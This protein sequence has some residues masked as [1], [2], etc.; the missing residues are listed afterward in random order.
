MNHLC[1]FIDARIV[2]AHGTRNSRTDTLHCFLSPQQD[3][4][5]SLD[6]VL[7]WLRRSSRDDTDKQN[8]APPEFISRLGF[9]TKGAFAAEVLR[10]AREACGGVLKAAVAR[11]KAEKALA[12][13]V[14]PSGTTPAVSPF[15]AAI[16]DSRANNNNAAAPKTDSRLNASSIGITDESQF[17]KLGGARRRLDGQGGS[18]GY[19]TVT[20]PAPT[21]KR[22]QPTST[23]SS[24]TAVPQSTQP[25]LP[26]ENITLPSTPGGDKTTPRR[27]TAVL[28]TS[29]SLGKLNAPPLRR[30][31]TL[32]FPG[33]STKKQK[34][35]NASF[36][37]ASETS[38]PA[39]AQDARSEAEFESAMKPESSYELTDAQTRL[40]T[41]HA[42]V[43]RF[44]IPP[45]LAPEVAFLGNLLSISLEVV[46]VDREGYTSKC[47]STIT[48]APA[49]RRYAAFVIEHC[50]S[51][52]FGV[53]ERL[54]AGLASSVS[55][56]RFA[57]KCHSQLVFELGVTRRSSLMEQRNGNNEDRSGGSDPSTSQESGTTFNF[58]N[59]A[60]HDPSHLDGGGIP[61]SGS[62]FGGAANTERA[63]R[64]REKSRDHL[65]TRLRQLASDGGGGGGGVSGGRHPPT[66][67]STGGRGHRDNYPDSSDSSFNASRSLLQSVSTENTRWFAELLVQRLCR[68]AVAGEHDAELSSV[69]APGR[70]SKLHKRLTGEGAKASTMQGDANS[71]GTASQPN[72]GGDRGR[73]RGRGG[74]TTSGFDRPSTGP[75]S[76]PAQ[77]TGA[78]FAVLFPSAQR[79]IVRLIETCDSHR[80]AQAL[81]RSLVNALHH[82]DPNASGHSVGD[83]DG[84]DDEAESDSDTD[85]AEHYDSGGVKVSQPGDGNTT[86]LPLTLSPGGVVPSPDDRKSGRSRRR[87][88]KLITKFPDTTVFLSGGITERALAL[89]AVA[90]VIGVL[91]FGS[92]AAGAGV[93]SAAALAPPA[94]VDCANALKR[95]IKNG[96]LLLTAPWVLSFLRFLPWDAEAATASCHLEPLSILRAVLRSPALCPDRGTPVQ[97]SGKD[98]D[99]DTFASQKSKV[100]FGAPQLALRSVLSNGLSIKAP[101]TPAARVTFCQQETL[102]SG[103]VLTNTAWPP[104]AALAQLP[105]TRRDPRWYAYGQ[106]VGEDSDTTDSSYVDPLRHW[107]VN[108]GHVHKSLGMLTGLEDSIDETTSAS[109]T[110]PPDFSRG[111]VD[112]RYLEWAC[113]DVDVAAT[114]LLRVAGDV[115]TSGFPST[116][117][118][119]A[120]GT[121]AHVSPQKKT[122]PSMPAAQSAHAEPS[123]PKT[124]EPA[125]HVDKTPSGSTAPR[126]VIASRI[127]EPD[128][129]E[130]KKVSR[131]VPTS[132]GLPSAEV[133]SVETKEESS[134]GLLKKTK[135][136]Q[137]VDR[138]LQRAFLAR[139]PA[140]RRVV[141]FVVDSASVAAA[142]LE[143]ASSAVTA[144]KR[145]SEATSAA[146]QTAAQVA[147][148]NCSPEDAWTPSLEDAVER[149]AMVAAREA[150][151]SASKR[152]ADDAA[153]RAMEAT[154]ALL[155]VHGVGELD[156]EMNDGAQK[157]VVSSAACAAAADAA[158]IAT[159]DRVRRT[160]PFALHAM[161]QSEA[162]RTLKTAL[163][164]FRE[165]VK[166]ERSLMTLPVVE[167]AVKENEVPEVSANISNVS[168]ASSS[169]EAACAAVTQNSNDLHQVLLSSQKLRDALLINTNDN[170]TCVTFEKNAKGTVQSLLDALVVAL[171]SGGPEKSVGSVL[172]SKSISR[173]SELHSAADAV[174]LVLLK[175]RV[176]ED[177]T[178]DYESN[179]LPACMTTLL[180]P[181]RWVIAL[182]TTPETPQTQRAVEGFLTQFIQ[183]VP[184]GAIGKQ[185]VRK[186]VASASSA[187]ESLIKAALTD[188]NIGC[189][190]KAV[191]LRAGAAL[192]DG[193]GD[194]ENGDG[195]EKNLDQK[196]QQKLFS[197]A[198]AIKTACQETGERRTLRRVDAVMRRLGVK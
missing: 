97:D 133:K 68:A 10:T 65:Y 63:Y 17:P 41:L 179:L 161:I 5:Q 176:A 66:G 153:K 193:F 198:L 58:L 178:N 165:I 45:D 52:P 34:D 164:K 88:G 148:Q 43:L 30:D 159:A 29:P 81:L 152:A 40:A 158:R 183:R 114:N 50:G 120:L 22:I 82:L 78:S 75:G 187:F 57:P 140:I 54:L 84:D 89:K 128:Q 31:D 175:L 71:A 80:L 146:A 154:S 113:P 18:G 15:V 69:V 185:S 127:V 170:T 156:G 42:Q 190:G 23:A 125:S 162:R 141:D 192:L 129:V 139:R 157:K 115:R 47:A 112:R 77:N 124:V 195:D 118:E 109:E 168:N 155:D 14:N 104:L 126:R 27:V 173:D 55:L 48:H 149:A 101:T 111:S 72:T 196:S 186:A 136:T 59:A 85:T 19:G 6:L 70:L 96:C 163:L 108:T 20:K 98:S 180:A 56:K 62:G 37:D 197:L 74:V 143:C 122:I 4:A 92:G 117:T 189:V 181:H 76:T 100:T 39:S 151:P 182:S 150:L 188:E 103:G 16:D 32:E 46:V 138:L 35:V 144:A 194:G 24:S 142:D 107:G 174:L 106:L 169:I 38:F 64:N 60:G 53:G 134:S 105:A 172:E 1:F 2:R 132:V 93:T 147:P 160:L 51:V 99:G 49:A 137:A 95:S 44:G 33:S 131:I 110:G 13:N 26:S 73:G 28:Y 79:P 36:F 145:A 67:R 8:D 90:G 116:F 7:D 135:N 91:V 87:K 3:E 21:K 12:V 191:V 61:G 9:S 171:F 83:D 86:T 184:V 167:E 102:R 177:G 25:V 94:G 11:Q 119:P 166:L 123:T 130:K 121:Q